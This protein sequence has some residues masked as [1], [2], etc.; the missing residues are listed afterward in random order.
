MCLLSR[1]RIYDLRITI[2]E[3]FGVGE[4]FVPGYVPGVSRCPLRCCHV[5]GG[6][7]TFEVGSW[8]VVCCAL[9]GCQ[10][11]EVGTKACR[12]YARWVAWDFNPRLKMNTDFQP[13]RRNII[14]GRKMNAEEVLGNSRNKNPLV[15]T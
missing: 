14:E 9:S 5:V 15:R 11:N 10:M 8:R 7:W 3:V 13:R 6:R 4:E 1:C 12:R 2:Y